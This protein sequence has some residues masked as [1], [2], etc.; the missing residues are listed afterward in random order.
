MAPQDETPRC[1]ERRRDAD[2]ERRP[3]RYTQGPKLK[4]SERR[5]G[6]TPKATQIPVSQLLRKVPPTVRPT[7]TAARRMVR[8]LAPVTEEMI[9][10]SRPPRSPRYMWKLLLYAV[11]GATILGIGT[12]PRHSTLYFYRGRELDDGAGSSKGVERRAGSSR[13]APQP[14]RSGRPSKSWCGRRS[15]SARGSDEGGN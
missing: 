8:A 10:M 11:D 5:V 1:R 6:A 3:Q 14:T 13:C 15:S 12:F 2:A 7:V 4:R 9:C